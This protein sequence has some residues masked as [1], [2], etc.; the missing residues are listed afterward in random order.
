MQLTSRLLN[1]KGEG[2]I[3]LPNRNIDYKL[4]PTISSGDVGGITVPIKIEGDLDNPTY[5]P[6][7]EEGVKL[8]IK[9]PEKLKENVKNIKND[10]KNLKGI[11]R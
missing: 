7:A 10:L 9:S 2:K 5:K 4:R 6:D 3:D 1:A 11:L 8:M